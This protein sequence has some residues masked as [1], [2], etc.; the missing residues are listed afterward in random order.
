MIGFLAALAVVFLGIWLGSQLLIAFGLIAFLMQALLGYLEKPRPVSQAASKPRLKHKLI[1]APEDAWKVQE[2]DIWQA[3]MSG[4]SPMSIGGQQD[5]MGL[6]SGGFADP[7]AVSAIRNMLPFQNYGREGAMGAV[8]N[9][10]IGF[11]IG[12]GKFLKR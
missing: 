8:E 4:P 5:F 12:I 11:P 10:F 7:H 3:M 6:A 1:D 2:D 9:L